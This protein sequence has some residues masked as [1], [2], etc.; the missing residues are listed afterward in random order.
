MN[1]TNVKVSACIDDITIWDTVNGKINSNALGLETNQEV[2][3]KGRIYNLKGS[4]QNE[5]FQIFLMDHPFENELNNQRSFWVDKNQLKITKRNLWT[6]ENKRTNYLDYRFMANGLKEID[7]ELFFKTAHTIKQF[8]KNSYKNYKASNINPYTIPLENE[9][10]HKYDE[11]LIQTNKST[12]KVQCLDKQENEYTF[13]TKEH[14]ENLTLKLLSSD[15]KTIARKPTN[16]PRKLFEF[17]TK[18]PCGYLLANAV[19]MRL[20]DM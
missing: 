17:R 10:I 1:T 18:T 20:F 11:I 6:E 14:P 2:S 9:E 16:E 13:L 12:L 8:N 5:S 15:F 4:H 7:Q 3:F 19:Q